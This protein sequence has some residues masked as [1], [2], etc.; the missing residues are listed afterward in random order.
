M[1]DLFCC[2]CEFFP[3]FIC[4]N[5]IGS[6]VN[7]LFG[8]EISNPFLS[9]LCHLLIMVCIVHYNIFLNY[10]LVVVYVVN[11]LILLGQLLV[12]HQNDY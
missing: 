3:A 2:F 9:F 7:S 8:V 1:S 12:M 6:L 10:L 11:C 5:N 4:A